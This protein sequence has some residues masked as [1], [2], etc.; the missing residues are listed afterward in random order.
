[1]RQ[2]L[3]IFLGVAPCYCYHRVETC[4][5]GPIL[6]FVSALGSLVNVVV[7]FTSGTCFSFAI[8]F[9]GGEGWADI[10]NLV[11]VILIIKI[12]GW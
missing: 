7:Y 9:Q 3:L 2:K 12:W 4:V 8:G 11:W 10:D 1:M 5:G 6:G